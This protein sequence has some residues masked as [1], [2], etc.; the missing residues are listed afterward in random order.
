[1]K[2]KV[3]M[4]D[5]EWT[6]FLA[7][8]I[9]QNT[10]SLTNLYLCWCSLWK[11]DTN[12]GINRLGLETMALSLRTEIFVRPDSPLWGETVSRRTTVL[13]SVSW[14]CSMLPASRKLLPRNVRNLKVCKEN[15]FMLVNYEENEVRTSSSRLSPAFKVIIDTLL[16]WNDGTRTLGF[17][18]RTRTESFSTYRQRNNRS[19]TCASGWR[20]WPKLRFEVGSGFVRRSLS[21]RACMRCRRYVICWNIASMAFI[22]IVFYKATSDSISS[23]EVKTWNLRWKLGRLPRRTS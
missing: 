15:Q 12:F 23:N 14:F 16:A 19:I 1:M 20:C 4:R 11:R 18:L 5:P 3:K 13:L 6:T 22:S 10:A 2:M 7:S 8:D 21:R 17:G 9:G